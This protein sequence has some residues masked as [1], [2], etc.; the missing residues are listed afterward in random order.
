MAG[1]EGP[2]S[3]RHVN[4]MGTGVVVDPR[5]Y[6]ITNYHVV[7]DVEDIRVTLHDGETTSAD[8]V[9]SRI[10]NDL[11]LIKFRTDGSAARNSA[12]HQQRFD[13]RRNR[14]RDR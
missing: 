14:D 4:G 12:R 13:G 8:L 5:G 6:V 1:A 3:F 2:D 11:A 7:E 9:T 10:R